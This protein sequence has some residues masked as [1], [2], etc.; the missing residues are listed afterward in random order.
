MNSLNYIPSSVFRNQKRQWVQKAE[1][2][3]QDFKTFIS[4]NH[5][6]KMSTVTLKNEL[7]EHKGRRTV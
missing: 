3:D 7:G 1:E 5:I 4:K 6:R 2:D